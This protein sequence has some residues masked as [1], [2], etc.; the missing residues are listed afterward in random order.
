M[1]VGIFCGLLVLAVALDFV[2][3]PKA[4]RRAW[5]AMAIAL[6]VVAS[7]VLFE[8]RWQALARRLGVGRPVDMLLYAAVAVLT[9]ELFLARA[10]FRMLERQ[11]TLLVRELALRGARM[12]VDSAPAAPLVGP[13]VVG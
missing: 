6:A 9:R 13:L 1:F 4:A 11:Q 5:Q 7:M 12:D 3:L 8:D 2:F 10:R